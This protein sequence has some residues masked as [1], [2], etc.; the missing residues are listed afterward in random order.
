MLKKV[1]E[2]KFLFF[3]ITVLYIILVYCH[4]NSFIISDDLTYSLFKRAGPRIT[5]I[6]EI[7][8][9]QI[10]DYSMLIVV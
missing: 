5:N 10:Y 6:F 2:N 1:K 3:F 4:M 9:N 8:E 7:I